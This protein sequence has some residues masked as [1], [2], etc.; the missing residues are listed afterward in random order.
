MSIFESNQQ[1]IEQFNRDEQTWRRRHLRRL[2]RRFNHVNAGAMHHDLL[3]MLAELV[4][5]KDL[6]IESTVTVKDSD[7][8][9]CGDRAE[10][11][12]GGIR[13]K[14]SG[15]IKS[16]L[17][18]KREPVGI[19]PSKLGGYYGSHQFQYLKSDLSKADGQWSCLPCAYVSARLFLD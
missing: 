10:L 13:E 2:E 18:F 14:V 11:L 12:N 3:D 8:H 15:G 5:R 1:V 6:L 19:S 7:S 9:H 4:E 17:E 16:F